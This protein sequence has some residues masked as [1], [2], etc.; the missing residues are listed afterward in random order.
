MKYKVIRSTVIGQ[1][2]VNVGDVVE[3]DGSEAV[4]LLGM[5]RIEEYKEPKRGRPKKVDDAG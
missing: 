4:A 3:V 1:Q 2:R 5:K